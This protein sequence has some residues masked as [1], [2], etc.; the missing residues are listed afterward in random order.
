MDMNEALIKTLSEQKETLEKQVKDLTKENN[1]L[2]YMASGYAGLIA[3]TNDKELIH[4]AAKIA[5]DADKLN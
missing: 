5:E 2:H 4:K 3:M 1:R